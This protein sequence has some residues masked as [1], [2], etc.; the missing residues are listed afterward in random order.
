MIVV[1]MGSLNFLISGVPTLHTFW[2]ISSSC[3]TVL[4][5]M[6]GLD[7]ASFSIMLINFPSSGLFSFGGLS[8]RHEML[9]LLMNNWTRGMCMHM[10]MGM[11]KELPPD[12]REIL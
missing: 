7:N 8:L 1:M 2:A 4:L 5:D 6:G 12:L 10:L 11:G 9:T 3:F